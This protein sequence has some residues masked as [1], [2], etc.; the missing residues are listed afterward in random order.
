M[1]GKLRARCPGHLDVIEAKR[2]DWTTDPFE[3]VEK[4]GYF[5]GRGTSDM[6]DG[7]AIMATTLLRMKR[8]GCRPSRDIISRSDRGRGGRLLQWGQLAA[9]ES[10]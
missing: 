8:E 4:D 1:D 3:L 2:E 6:K 7:E 9:E 10:P 5:Y